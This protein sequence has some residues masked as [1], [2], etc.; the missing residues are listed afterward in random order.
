MLFVIALVS[1]CLGGTTQ[2]ATTPGSIDGGVNEGTTGGAAL[3]DTTPVKDTVTKTVSERIVLVDTFKYL[4]GG[5]EQ[6]DTADVIFTQK[7]DKGWEIELDATDKKISA[8]IMT[9]KDCMAKYKGETY[10]VISPAKEGTKISFA[11]EDVLNEARNLC[12]KIKAIDEGEI[13]INVKVNGLTFA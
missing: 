12:I 10:E 8:E 7:R 6:F 1:G 2:V 11:S 13:K 3:G 5:R 9:D 4:T